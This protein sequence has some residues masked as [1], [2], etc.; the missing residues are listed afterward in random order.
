MIEFDALSL[1]L[2]FVPCFGDEPKNV[3]NAK[4]RKL[5]QKNQQHSHTSK[6]CH[7]RVAI[8]EVLSCS[9]NKHLFFSIARSP[10]KCTQNAISVC[11]KNRI[12]AMQSQ[13]Y[14]KRNVQRELYLALFLSLSLSLSMRWSSY[15]EIA[16]GYCKA[17]ET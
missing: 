2:C 10:E 15:S 7:G 3:L 11:T 8:G 4:P 6:C 5:P 12:N 14:N 1:F 9:A 16:I 17:H 13:P